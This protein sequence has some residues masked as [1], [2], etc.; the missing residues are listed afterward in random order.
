MKIKRIF[1]PDMRQA[2]RLVREELGPDAVILSNKNVEGGVEIVAARDYDE[3]Q[4][5][6]RIQQQEGQAS[7]A[8]VSQSKPASRPIQQRSLNNNNKKIREAKPSKTSFSKSK[9]EWSQEPALVEMKQELKQMRRVIDTHLS[10]VGWEASART[11]PTRID[12]LKRMRM[13][14][15]STELSL[16]LANSVSEKEDSETAW[17]KALGEIANQLP[18]VE[19]NL[20]DY[21]GI[22]A[23]VGPTGVGK[24]TTIAKLA[25]RYKLAHG[26]RHIALVTT[27]NYRIA[28]HE[29]LSTYGR[30]L[31]VPVRTASNS[32]ELNNILNSFIDKRLV[33]IDTAGMSQRDERL[34]EQFSLLRESTMPIKSYLVMSATTQ[35]RGLEEVIRTFQGFDPQAAILTKIDEAYTLGATVSALIKN[36]L[37]LAWIT[38]GQKVPEDLHI[39]RPNK[40]LNQCVAHENSGYNLSGDSNYETWFAQVNV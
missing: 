28:A 40:L 20:L 31:D 33:L 5:Q 38:N 9:I 22:V 11:N 16:E 15:F 7:V 24:T 17:R 34:V 23:L 37:P 39:A 4:V 32:S 14:D 30:I 36:Q 26:S 10:Q 29:Q 12:L 13:A 8:P 27:D 3:Q 18:T 2:I 1:A 21:G 19:D 35:D 6:N 25:A